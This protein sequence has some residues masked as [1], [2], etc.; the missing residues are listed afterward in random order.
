MKLYNKLKRRSNVLAALRLATFGDWLIYLFWFF[1]RLV[2]G[3]NGNLIEFWL[4]SL[5]FGLI[6]LGVLKVLQVDF[7][8]LNDSL[9]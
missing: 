3:G 1:Y 9:D 4:L 5:D 2:D 7:S 8:S 6:L